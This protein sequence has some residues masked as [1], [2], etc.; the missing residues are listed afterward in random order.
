MAGTLP[1]TQ[2][3]EV[4]WLSG[5]IDED[6]D[7]LIRSLH[8]VQEKC[9]NGRFHLLLETDIDTIGH[10]K[11]AETRVLFSPTLSFSGTTMEGQEKAE[12]L[13]SALRSLSVMALAV[14]NSCS[15]RVPSRRRVCATP[16]D[17]GEVNIPHWFPGQAYTKESIQNDDLWQKMREEKLEINA[18]FANR[19]SKL[20][21][22]GL[23][24]L[25]QS[26]FTHLHIDIRKVNR[27]LMHNKL[28]YALFTPPWIRQQLSVGDRPVCY[29]AKT[30]SLEIVLPDLR[31]QRNS[32][33]HQR[34]AWLLAAF[35]E[36]EPQLSRR[37]LDTLIQQFPQ[38]GNDSSISPAKRRQPAPRGGRRKKRMEVPSKAIQQAPSPS[39]REPA[40]RKGPAADES[41]SRQAGAVTFNGHAIICAFGL[42]CRFKDHEGGQDPSCITAKCRQ[43]QVAKMHDLCAGGEEGDRICPLCKTSKTS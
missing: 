40:V 13:V 21:Q 33:G 23:R 27:S 6:V 32:T 20:S 9:S 19:F 31:A 43:C 41:P 37:L 30:D 25:Y 38:Q 17:G 8:N 11:R 42:S 2:R 29:L 28:E 7:D 5:G 26:F 22:K 3:R 12:E 18:D 1:K 39:E 34:M 35:Y 36:F 15:V 16:S 10:I 24:D 14:V 4:P